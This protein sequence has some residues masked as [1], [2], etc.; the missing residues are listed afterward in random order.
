MPLNI[1]QFVNQAVLVM[2]NT[3]RPQLFK[4]SSG[5]PT[6][7]A[8]KGIIT[9]ISVDAFGVVTVTTS[10]PH[11]IDATQGIGTCV[12]LSGI[13]NPLYNSNSLTGVSTFVTIAIPSA[14][15]V[16]LYNPSIIGQAA[17]SGGLMVVTTTPIQSTFTTAYPLWATGVTYL[18]GDIVTPIVANGHYYKATQ[19]GIS[20]AAPPAFPTASGA[21]VPESTPSQVIW[22]EAGLTN[23]TA[24]APPGASHMVVFAGS[25]WAWDTSPVN[26]TTGLDGPCSLRMSDAN[27]PN[28]WNP[29][30]QAF[31]DKDDGTEGMGIAA[32]TIA[33]FGI[34]P[35]GSL[36]AFKQYAGYQ[37]VG[38]FGS[39]NFLIQR[40]KSTLGCTA[41]R[42]IQ[43]TTGFGLTRFTHLGFA[44]FDGINDKVIDEDIHN[45]IFPVNEID[46]SDITKVDF[47]FLNLAW[48]SQTS[49]PA[50]YVAALPIGNSGGKLTRLFCYDLVLK[51][52]A[53]ID[54]P[55]AIS[56]I[57]QALTNI[58]IP[59]TLL[60][61]FDDGAIHRWQAG[62]NLWDASIDAGLTPQQVAWSLEL[63]MLYNQRS[64]GG[65]MYCRQ[66]VS[67]GKL[68]DSTASIQVSV[69]V[70]GETAVVANTNQYNLGSDGTFHLI[71]A[72]DEKFTNL[73]IL[74]NGAGA[75]ELQSFD[76]QTAP[77]SAR[78]PPRLT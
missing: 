11:G 53:V 75:V 13:L 77:L 23:T 34:P 61:T 20:A 27:N 25:L 57:G 62:D 69:R 2:G 44:V 73:S 9:A 33:G 67:R 42:T 1:L 6:N 60:S 21:Q 71:T 3:F 43:F 72:I 24:P 28:S 52:W 30:N 19:G 50:M 47:N 31:L 40:I 58:S 55:F 39:P 5:S 26:T 68:T 51:A 38:V 48:A 17:S 65:R 15:T 16:T 66:I 32:F 12:S 76:P 4:D 36:V 63:P 56:H 70:Q 37:I 74:V 8:F 45:Y 7:P 54:L 46:T 10:L 41:A 14:T 49:V 35:E 22:Q 64:P 78:T 59:V 18:V 29:I